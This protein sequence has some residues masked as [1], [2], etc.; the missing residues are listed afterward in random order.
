M[1]K[2]KLSTGTEWEKKVGYSRGIRVGNAIEIAGTTAVDENGNFYG[3]GSFYEQ[4]RYIILKAKDAIEKL[5][6]QL[7]DVTRTR[8][9][10]T[11][12]DHWDMVGKAHGEFFSE[13]RPAVTMVEVSRLILPEILVEIEFSAVVQ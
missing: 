8:I 7:E 6:G 1:D 13:I 4:T 9:F 10:V 12:I 2:R 11:D 3:A 5:G